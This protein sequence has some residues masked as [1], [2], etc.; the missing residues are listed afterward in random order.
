MGDLWEIYGRY[1]GDIALACAGGQAAQRRARRLLELR[2][3]LGLGLGL[4]IGIGLG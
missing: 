2:V 3:G 1:R 4:G